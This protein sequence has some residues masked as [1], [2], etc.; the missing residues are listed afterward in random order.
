[1]QVRLQHGIL[2]YTETPH[3]LVTAFQNWLQ[4]RHGW[5]VPEEWLVWLPGVVPGLNLTAKSVASP[6]GS[7]L[8]PTPVYHPFLHVAE[9][10]GQASIKGGRRWKAK[11]ALC[12]LNP[13]KQ[14]R[15]KTWR[16]CQF[17]LDKSSEN[18]ITWNQ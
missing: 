9:H 16:S 12:T 2:G 6:G 7:I 5:S 1:M 18:S 11:K 4:R 8:I 14:S 17:A 15:L 13:M 3:D 10:V